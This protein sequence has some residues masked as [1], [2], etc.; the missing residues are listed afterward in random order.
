L[1]KNP[2]LWPWLLIPWLIDIAL[3]VLGWSAGMTA[4]QGWIT[5][6]VTGW[7]GSGFWFDLLN[8]PIL[9]VFGLIFVVVW[10]IAVMSVATALASPF[11]SL[12]AEKVLVLKGV[13]GIGHKGLAGWVAHSIK[14]L[15]VGLLKGGIFAAMGFLL[16]AVSFIPGLNFVAAYASMCLFAAD[17]FD[18][19]FE[20]RGFSLKRRVE[21]VRKMGG[22]V[23]GLGASLSLTSVIPGLTVLLLPL[24]VVGA[25]WQMEKPE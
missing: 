14:M 9:I 5:A 23:L 11:N 6:L 25:T 7:V 15:L 20:A 24:A 3:L 18:Y 10:L 2:S 13:Q 19:G 4:I 16:F 8:Y 12:L 22:V 17:M 1:R 21:E